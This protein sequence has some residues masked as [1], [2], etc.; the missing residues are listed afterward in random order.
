MT[1]F[2][3]EIEIQQNVNYFFAILPGISDVPD[4]TK[5]IQHHLSGK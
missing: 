4:K 3:A 5:V 2:Y 1:N